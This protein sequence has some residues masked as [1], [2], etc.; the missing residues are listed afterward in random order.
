[1][2]ALK[3]SEASFQR[4]VIDYAR[5][6]HWRVAHF[7]DSRRQVRPGV[8]VGDKDAAG[9][10]DLVMVRGELL[11]IAELKAGRGR[12]R[13]EQEAWLRALWQV[14]GV[15]VRLWSP[16]DWADIESTLRRRP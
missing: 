15:T 7:H 9:F 5:A 14:P 4:A 13:P 1:M 3:Q 8:L 10:P 11:V 2:T 16:E 12:V 6:N